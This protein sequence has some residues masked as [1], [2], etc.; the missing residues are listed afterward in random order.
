MNT[1]LDTPFDVDTEEGSQPF[2]PLPPG[3]Y[4]A[5]I[6]TAECGRT[7]NGRGVRV[8]LTWQVIDGPH[9]ERMVFQ[10]I[11][12]EHDS[13]KAQKIGRGMFKDVCACC[14]I[15]EP[16]T[17]LE[18]LYFKPCAI[19]VRIEKDSNGQYP[20]KNKVVRVDPVGVLA[21]PQQV[22][23]KQQADAL[24]VA[25]KAEPSFKATGEDMDDQIPF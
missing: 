7:N 8:S 25:S 19:S 11:L 17:D 9:A 21:S 14:G 6:F 20:D 23:A 16:V 3:K 2:E 12:I 15:T 24:R 18:V 5:E 22:Q 10:H 13:E 1:R 4:R